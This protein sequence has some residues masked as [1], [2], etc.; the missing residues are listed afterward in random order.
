MLALF[1]ELGQFVH[2]SD[3]A[4]R[5]LVVLARARMR[6]TLHLVRQEPALVRHAVTEALDFER[7][8]DDAFAYDVMRENA[9][10]GNQAADEGEQSKYRVASAGE[11]GDESE[12]ENEGE[13]R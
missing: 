7:S 1:H 13:E 3:P 11:G 6:R 10:G 12:D 5:E 8:V 9:S 4:L 2:Y